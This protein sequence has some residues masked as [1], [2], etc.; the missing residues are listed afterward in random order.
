MATTKTYATPH[1][2]TLRQNRTP[3]SWIRTITTDLLELSAAKDETLLL[4]LRS[5]Q[6]Y[7]INPSLESL[8][9]LADVYYD[10]NK[11]TYNDENIGTIQ[12]R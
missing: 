8:F 1:L 11:E 5:G 4:D 3:N 9:L 12:K 2:H 10:D 6:V 7:L